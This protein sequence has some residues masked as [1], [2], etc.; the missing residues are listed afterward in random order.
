[1]R[2]CRTDQEPQSRRRRH[3]HDPLLD[4][5]LNPP[6]MSVCTTITCMKHYIST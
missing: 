6:L 2:G 1:M 4:A 5:P 3:P